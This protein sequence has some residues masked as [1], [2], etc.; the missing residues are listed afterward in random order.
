MAK[1]EASNPQ[2]AGM[3]KKLVRADVYKPEKE[4]DYV[5]GTYV[6]IQERPGD[7]GQAYD[8]ILVMKED[9]SL[10]SVYAGADVTACVEKD[11][12]ENDTI[13]LVF[14]GVETTRKGRKVHIWD[15]YCQE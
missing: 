1:E 6:G 11:F 7:N 15:V 2:F 9:G 10:V 12:K 14:R 4:G 5:K 13:L 3:K 8:V